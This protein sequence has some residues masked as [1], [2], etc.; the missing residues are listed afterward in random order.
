MLS[1]LI[2]RGVR[3][4]PSGRS[5]RPI[6]F[7]LTNGLEWIFGM[8]KHEP[9]DNGEGDWTCIRT[10]SHIIPN[11]GLGPDTDT[12]KKSEDEAAT[13]TGIRILIDMLLHWICL[14][15]DVTVNQ[16]SECEEEGGN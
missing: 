5:P 14:E 15:P 7:I 1:C 9:S 6:P 10:E 2:L 3:T 11:C 16:L 4:K 8:L 12:D 13:T